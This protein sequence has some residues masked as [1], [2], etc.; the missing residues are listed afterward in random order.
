M[1]KKLNAD[2]KQA[3]KAGEVARFVQQYAR[4]A[5]S[6]LDPNDRGYDRGIEA[7]IKR[8]RPEELDRLLREDEA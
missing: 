8:M 2:E 7:H 4:K 5:R 6:G 3:R 1:A